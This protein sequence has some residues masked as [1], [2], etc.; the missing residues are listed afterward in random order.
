MKSMA[1][2]KIVL[3]IILTLLLNIDSKA[4]DSLKV[5][6]L[7]EINIVL[8]KMNFFSINPRINYGE[9]QSKDVFLFEDL[10]TLLPSFN[11]QTNSRGES[12][13]TY[14]GSQERQTNFFADG[15]LLSIPWDAR[16]DLGIFN[17]NIIGRIELLPVSVLYGPNNMMGIVSMTTFE[18]KYNGFGGTA[19]VQLGDGNAKNLSFTHDGR[20]NNFNYILAANFLDVAG[21]VASKNTPEDLQNYDYNSALITNSYFKQ[22]NFY[23]KTEYKI[24][25]VFAIGTSINYSM[26]D[27]GVIPEEHKKPSKARFW[28]YDDND[29]FLF[30]LN[31]NW[32]LDN[33]KMKFTYWLDKTHQ[34]IDS[35]EDITYSKRKERESNGDLTNGFR[36]INLYNFSDNNHIALAANAVLTTHDEDI[37]SFVNDEAGEKEGKTENTQFSQNLFSLSSEYTH[38]F[39]D[40]LE[41]KIG[42][43]F[44]YVITPKAGKFIEANNTKNSDFGAIFTANYLLNQRNTLFGNFSRKIRFPSLRES[45]SAALGKFKVNPDLAPE[46]NIL[47]EIGYLFSNE[48]LFCKATLFA[49]FYDDMIVKTYDSESGLEMRANIASAKIFGSEFIL[50][51]DITKHL[52]INANFTYMYSEGTDDKVN[53]EHLDYR[54]VVAGALT[55]NVLTEIGV[56]SSVEL[57]FIGKQYALAGENQFDELDPTCLLNL[58]LSYDIFVS[59]FIVEA[60][61]RCNNI[62]STYRRIKIGIPAP[63]RE[64]LCGIIIKI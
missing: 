44:D 29:R 36:L 28:K 26:Y 43:E 14:R 34:N 2:Y 9:I 6:K 56:K 50:Q 27:K 15:A 62:F 49:N 60:Y 1:Y 33:N 4:V 21:K 7:G 57:D 40:K 32:F 46:T 18:R 20:I 12:I 45:Y 8:D 19:K 64:F 13:F 51:Y 30:T 52:N 54:P 42:A 48:R 31:S 25:E 53:I 17:P 35:Y 59:N 22:K 41:T 38:K 11:L 3:L 61:A 39:G 10:K 47:A 55:T 23:G 58:R 24:G 16:A 37:I 5:Y 63:G